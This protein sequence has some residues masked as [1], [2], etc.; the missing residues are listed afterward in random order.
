MP[1]SVRID[2]DNN[3]YL[4]SR[5]PDIVEEVLRFSGPVTRIGPAKHA[6][7]RESPTFWAQVYKSINCLGEYS[8][9]FPI[10]RLC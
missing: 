4:G 9:P 6:T 7:M 10:I 5:N 3:I 8:Y 2:E 1:K